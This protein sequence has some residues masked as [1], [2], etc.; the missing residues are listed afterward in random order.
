MTLGVVIAAKVSTAWT[1]GCKALHAG[2]VYS[3][4]ES[5]LVVVILGRMPLHWKL[6]EVIRKLSRHVIDINESLLRPLSGVLYC[7]SWAL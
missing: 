4:C 2:T 7:M 1:Q 6:G 3:L 5:D